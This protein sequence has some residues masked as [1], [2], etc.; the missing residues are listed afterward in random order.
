MWL[1]DVPNPQYFHLPVVSGRQA[2]RSELMRVLYLASRFRAVLAISAVE[3]YHIGDEV[4]IEASS[5]HLC[6]DVDRN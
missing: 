1:S 3:V 6:G 4:V 5:Y 2:D